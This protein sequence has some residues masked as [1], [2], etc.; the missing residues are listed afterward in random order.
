M[1]SGPRL[2]LMEGSVPYIPCQIRHYEAKDVERC[3]AARAAKGKKTW[4]AFVGDSNQRQK[5][6]SLMRFLPPELMYTFYLGNKQVT[7][8]EFRR[9]VTYHVHRPPTFDILGRRPSTTSKT[10]KTSTTSTTTTSS[11][12]DLPGSYHLDTSN[13][14]HSDTDD[15]GGYRGLKRDS[16]KGSSSNE[17]NEHDN[18]NGQNGINSHNGFNGMNGQDGINGLNG[19]N[20]YGINRYNAINGYNGTD[21]HNSTNGLNNNGH[22][23]INGHTG[24][25]AYDENNDSKGEEEEEDPSD[26]SYS[27]EELLEEDVPLDSYDLRVT[28]V[29]APGGSLKIMSSYTED[30]LEQRVT[31]LQDWAKGDVV[32]D[33]MVVGY[34]TWFIVMRTALGELSH[35]TN[36]HRLSHP[37]V[38]TLSRLAHKTR[39]LLWS[40][41][42]Y[43]WFNFENADVS[44]NLKYLLY[45]TQ[46]RDSLP[47]MDAWLWSLLRPT[48][49]W[50]WDSTLPFNL[51]NLR[52]C[53]AYK[54]AKLY[55]DPIY[56]RKASWWQCNDVQHASFETNANEIH[57]LFNFLCNSYLSTP[58]QY[59]CS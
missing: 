35:F 52:E 45:I 57:M 25:G 2:Q 50:Q 48:G 34:A 54:Q 17:K 10:T 42:R 21:S 59:C 58:Q 46:F 31:K 40:Q 24:L 28:L 5:V 22:N 14:S 55:A 20:D 53:Q 29:W 12:S 44:P 36:L 51:A 4:I 9:A 32:P 43:R 37:L 11:T 23:G 56:S 27:E 13:H 18:F 7:R 15:A 26:F 30:H 38:Q 33:V 49:T 41:S 39:M 8:E 47:L 1:H 3:S 16:N 19:A 6:Y